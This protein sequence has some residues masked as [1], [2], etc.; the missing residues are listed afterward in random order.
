MYMTVVA[1][2]AYRTMM[3]RDDDMAWERYFTL[4]YG[5]AGLAVLGVRNWT[6]PEN[7]IVASATHASVAARMRPHDFLGCSAAAVPVPSS[8]A[9]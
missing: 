2:T 4:A 6:A 1:L 3:G 7:A 5:S 8:T 9:A